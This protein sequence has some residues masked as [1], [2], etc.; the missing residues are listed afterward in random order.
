[1]TFIFVVNPYRSATGYSETFETTTS[2]PRVPSK[3]VKSGSK[4]VSSATI[5]IGNI[6]TMASETTSGHGSLMYLEFYSRCKHTLLAT[7]AG[8]ETTP[9][10]SHSPEKVSV[11]SFESSSK[12]MEPPT[13]EQATVISSPVASIEIEEDTSIL[14]TKAEEH[15]KEP[16]G[17]YVSESYQIE[18]NLT[19]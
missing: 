3:Q 4:D 14:G 11:L 12:E 10:T 19:A 5:G 18:S 15:I 8:F 9:I 7:D 2:T 17:T 1:M 16:D 13:P 6:T